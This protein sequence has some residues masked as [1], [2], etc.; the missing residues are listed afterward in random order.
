MADGIGTPVSRPVQDLTD[1]RF[2]KLVVRRPAERK[3]RGRQWECVCDCGNVAVKAER[4]LLSGDTESCGHRCALWFAKRHGG[5]DLPEYNVW[6]GMKRRCCC[7]TSD[8]YHRYGGRGIR[9][10][11]RWLNSFAD[12]LADM[13]PRPS[14][15][16]QLERIDNDGNYEPGNCRWAT[17]LEQA[18]NTRRNL[19]IEIDGRSQSFSA[20]CEEIGVSGSAIYSRV[21]SHGTTHEEE[22]RRVIQTGR[23][24]LSRRLAPE[25]VAAIRTAI[26]AGESQRSIARRLGVS[27]AAIRDIATGRRHTGV[28]AV[29]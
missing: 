12:F 11:E 22:I 10:C 20:W 21:V 6:S 26:A 1:R 18:R 8:D 14:P 24:D 7:Q 23:T 4:H 28:G 9:V 25:T 19:V 2:G 13:G 29:A 16:H 27:R 3:N 5:H 15:D 17:R